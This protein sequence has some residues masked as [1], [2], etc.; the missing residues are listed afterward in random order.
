MPTATRRPFAPLLA[1]VVIALLVLTGSAPPA[2][3]DDAGD[4]PT[5]PQAVLDLMWA[6]TNAPEAGLTVHY[7]YRDERLPYLNAVELAELRATVARAPQ[8]PDGWILRH[9]DALR[10]PDY[11]PPEL[12][13]WL[14]PG[15]VRVR[16]F[17]GFTPLNFGV[18]DGEAWRLTT[19]QLALLPGP[20]H[21][22]GNLIRSITQ[23]T[24]NHLNS[25]LN[26]GLHALHFIGATDLPELE[27]TERGYRL[28]VRVDH[29]GTVDR[30]RFVVEMV[31]HFDWLPP[32]SG[33]PG[34]P[35][36]LAT[37]SW[38]VADANVYLDQVG[39]R[40][41]YDGW[42]FDETLGRWRAS[43]ITKRRP[44]G[45][46]SDRLVWLATEPLQP[47]VARDLAADPSLTEPDPILGE[48]T[49]TSFVDERG[50]AALYQD[51]DPHSRRRTGEAVEVATR[52]PGRSP[53]VGLDGLPRLGVYRDHAPSNEPWR[54]LGYASAA[55]LVV[56]LGLVVRSRRGG[57]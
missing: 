16:E 4:H 21:E 5:T 50:G 46:A 35:A 43:T 44:D 6:R 53:A 31:Y 20:D 2:A 9:H 23:R 56:A 41:D 38:T 49:L 25:F 39:E 13:V 3:A 14:G 42:T 12:H 22:R 10:H 26:G 17:G 45:R 51:V 27:R 48:P 36:W 33:G 24:A 7:R 28:R 55:L 34:S 37:R 18:L 54:W 8:H 57:A 47:R 52:S 40:Y 30:D 15:A 1:A 11:R 32:G 29:P 19:E